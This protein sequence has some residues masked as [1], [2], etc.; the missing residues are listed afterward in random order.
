MQYKLN[1]KFVHRLPNQRANAR[2]LLI[3][4]TFTLS[5]AKSTKRFIR[6]YESFTVNM[7]HVNLS[8]GQL[9]T[10]KLT[11]LL[12]YCGLQIKTCGHVKQWQ[13]LA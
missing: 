11:Y 9:Y 4:S 1:A 3:K 8:C 5:T 7:P 6:C 12:T 2:V 13:C 10:N